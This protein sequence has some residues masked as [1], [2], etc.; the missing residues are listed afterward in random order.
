MRLWAFVGFIFKLVGILQRL[1]LMYTFIRLFSE[2]YRGTAMGLLSCF[3]LYY[4]FCNEIMYGTKQ[5]LTI[6]LNVPLF[7][8][9]SSLLC[10]LFFFNHCITRPRAWLLAIATARSKAFLKTYQ[11]G[12]LTTVK[13]HAHFKH[14]L[15]QR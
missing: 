7:W 12:L 14:S 5:K 1:M 4:V 6:K 2:L 3:I 9:I 15:C 11:T 8:I 10:V 13:K